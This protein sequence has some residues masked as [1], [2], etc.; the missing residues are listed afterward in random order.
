MAGKRGNG[1]VFSRG[2]VLSVPGVLPP[3]S[4]FVFVYFLV[5]GW[6]VTDSS[7]GVFG[8]GGRRDTG[9]HSFDAHGGFFCIGPFFGIFCRRRS[10]PPPP[11]TPPPPLP[12]AV[13]WTFMSIPFF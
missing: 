12:P 5:D 1:T 2:H 10:L 8:G 7:I 4:F 6:R 13:L 11:G 3:S 9:G